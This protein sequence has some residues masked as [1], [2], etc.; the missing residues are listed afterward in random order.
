MCRQVTV[1]PYTSANPSPRTQRLLS[2]LQDDVPLTFT[3]QHTGMSWKAY[4]NLYCA[5]AKALFYHEKPLLKL[6]LQAIVL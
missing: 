1:V 4:V 2:V 5:G 3:E 6:D